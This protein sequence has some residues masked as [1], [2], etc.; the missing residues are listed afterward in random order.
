MKDRVSGRRYTVIAR[1]EVCRFAQ[2]DNQPARL[3]VN[4]EPSS[5]YVLG[6]LAVQELQRRKQVDRVHPRQT[7]FNLRPAWTMHHPI[8][9]AFRAVH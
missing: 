9:L 3:H 6:K 5:S 4:R 8:A 2:T 1:H 7:H